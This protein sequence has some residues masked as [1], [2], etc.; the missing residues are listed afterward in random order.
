VADD[1][2]YE[3][4]LRRKTAN[5]LLFSSKYSLMITTEE[6]GRI[7]TYAVLGDGKEKTGKRKNFGQRA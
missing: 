5:L 4:N 7:Y 6:L 3:R 2:Q 1:D